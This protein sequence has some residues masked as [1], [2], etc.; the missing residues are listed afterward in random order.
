MA[1]APADPSQQASRWVD[2]R[3]LALFALAALVLLAGNSAT[4]VF[5]R[6]E[7]RFA[8]AV[9]EMSARSDW[10]LPTNWGEPRYH[11][12]IL[13]Y[14]CALAAERVFGPHEF[15]WRL[16]S[17]LA[18]LVTLAA[19][20]A[21]ARRHFGAEVALRAGAILATTSVFVLESKILTADVLLLATTTLA[22]WAW[23]ELR[24]GSPRRFAW[25]LLF[26]T[27]L[28][29][30][31]LAKG[32]NVVFLAAAA[33]GLCFLGIARAPE[34]RSTR[35][36][37]LVVLAAASVLAAVP[38][39][40]L[41]GPVLFGGCALFLWLR[42]APSGQA[43]ELGTAWG[44]PLCAVLVSVWAVPALL[45]SR[46]EFLSQGLGHH[47]LARSA[48]PFEKHAGF[49]GYYL[50][51]GVLALF[52]WAL[53]IPAA[54]RDAWRDPRCEFFLAWILGPWALLECLASKLPHYP[55]VTLP[56]LAILIALHGAK[57]SLFMPLATAVAL[58]LALGFVALPL[59]E[60]R[61]LTPRL[62]AEISRL[63]LPGEAIHVLD[64]RPAS[65]GCVLP[66]GHRIVQDPSSVAATDAE[67]AP[68]LYVVTAEREGELRAAGQ[69]PFLPLGRVAGL[70]SLSRREI[71]LLRRTE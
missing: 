37:L 18:G 62:G 16:P 50:L 47:M 8:L 13:A 34:A 69:A 67:R 52:P 24:A 25:Q 40:G 27:A 64:F 68:G 30:G 33:A 49:P 26:W 6:D 22:F 59:Y 58:Y 44:L 1:R 12:P 5:D 41:L 56:A 11:K 46:G 17:V 21:L 35:N 38:G 19:T 32:V 10:V 15:A 60:A 42:R 55:L 14:W 71:A 63:V 43:A 2:W 7:A 39:L 61:R 66:P 53:R 9:R 23:L 3:V 36:R 31:I 54:L 65:L 45:R 4:H 20:L 48:S 57:R 70:D 29:L 28:A 51:T